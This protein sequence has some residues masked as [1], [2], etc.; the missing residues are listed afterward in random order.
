MSK[1]L[2][3]AAAFAFGILSCGSPTGS[4]NTPNTSTGTR[5]EFSQRVGG[6]NVADPSNWCAGAFGEAVLIS[7]DPKN[8]QRRMFALSNIPN[9]V[10]V[11]TGHFSAMFMLRSTGKNVEILTGENMPA[12]LSTRNNFTLAADGKSFHYDNKKGVSFDLHLQELPNGLQAAID[13]PEE[14]SLGLTAARCETCK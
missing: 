7:P 10:I 14:S 9:R 5:M 4:E 2:S 3:F 8:S 13:L 6:T 12:C 1:T 11:E